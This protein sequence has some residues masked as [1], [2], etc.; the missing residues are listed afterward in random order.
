MNVNI[1]KQTPLLD[2]SLTERTQVLDALAAAS[3]LYERYVDIV[4]VANIAAL[5]QTLQTVEVQ[6]VPPPLG[7][8]ICPQ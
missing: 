2:N 7:L 3:M 8:V 5:N 1:H 6:T 4:D